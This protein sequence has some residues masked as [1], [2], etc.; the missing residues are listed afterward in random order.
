MSLWPLLHLDSRDVVQADRN[1]IEYQ[2]PVESLRIISDSPSGTTSRPKDLYIS[3]HFACRSIAYH[4][5][6]PLEGPLCP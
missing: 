4:F 1:I 3:T 5:V 6:S 2:N